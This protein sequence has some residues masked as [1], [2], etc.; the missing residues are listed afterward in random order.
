MRVLGEGLQLVSYRR[1][2][3]LAYPLT[4]CYAGSVVGRSEPV[5][6]RLIPLVMFAAT[7]DS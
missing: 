3:F 7:I 4:G 2:D 5:M 6:R 1:S